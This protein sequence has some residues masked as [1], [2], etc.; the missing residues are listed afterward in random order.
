M[1]L[2][3]IHIR[4]AESRDLPAINEIYNHYVLTSTTTY[5]EVPSTLEERLAW[6]T[7]RPAGHVVTVAE[8]DGRVVGWGSLGTFRVRSA[9]RFTV[10]NSV[11][12]QHEMHRRGIGSTLLMDQIRRAREHGFRVIVAGIDAEQ[13]ASLALHARHGFIETGRL[14]G[15]GL[16]FGRWLDIV[17]MTLSLDSAGV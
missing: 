14:P 4:L 17:F 1:S 8:L 13:D 5:Q 3:S 10:E 7:G 9:Y 16:K 11:Y 15:V 6:F 12:V 2:P